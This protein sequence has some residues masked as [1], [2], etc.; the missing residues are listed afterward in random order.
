MA[1]RA[2]SKWSH[3]EG[4][5]LQITTYQRT[6]HVVSQGNEKESHKEKQLS[7]EMISLLRSDKNSHQTDYA[8]F[9]QEWMARMRRSMPKLDNRKH[10]TKW[11]DDLKWS[12]RR[13]RFEVVHHQEYFDVAL[14]TQTTHGHCS[15]PT[16][17]SSFFT[18]LRKCW[19]IGSVKFTMWEKIG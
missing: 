13:A 2:N 9:R 10:A 6:C 3:K 5:W 1:R 18:S 15:H 16:V 11:H 4:R 19:T 14:F 17:D 7:N 8:C 12:T